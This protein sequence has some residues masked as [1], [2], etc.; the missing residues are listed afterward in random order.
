M[1][2]SK[3]IRKG[4]KKE[5]KAHVKERL[6]SCIG[7]MFLYGLPFF[8]LTIMMYGAIFGRVFAMMATSSSFVSAEQMEMVMAQSLF[9][10]MNSIGLVL[11]LMIV[12]AGPL[13]F[14]MMKYYI[15]LR[16]GEQPTVGLLFH[17]FTSLHSV[18][19]GIKMELC[20][21]LRSL[22]WMIGPMLIYFLIVTGLSVGMAMGGASAG[23]MAGTMLA[24]EIVFILAMIP[25]S[26][27]LMTYNAGWIILDEDESYGAWAASRDASHAFS[28]HY[29]KLFVFVLSFLPWYLLVFGVVYG[30]ILLGV[31]GMSMMGVTGSGIAVLVLCCIAAI[32]LDIVVSAFLSAYMNTSF[33]GLYE[34]F[35]EARKAAYQPLV[36]PVYSA[37]VQPAEPQQTEDASD[38]PQSSDDSEEQ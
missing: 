1:E 27:K 2:Y 26:V 24:L 33:I 35:D 34:Y 9:S 12:I 5:C 30:C 7:L 10:S 22:I 18:W 28:G 14:G 19:T 32:I 4:I 25:I 17:P 3:E 38:E 21:M 13:Q 15:A 23:S 31:F 6:G 16:R 37:P 11:V 20:L 8:L 36:N 29:G